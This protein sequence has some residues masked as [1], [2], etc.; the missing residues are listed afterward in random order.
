MEENQSEELKIMPRGTAPRSLRKGRQHFLLIVFRNFLDLQERLPA[1][2]Q[3]L[4]SRLFDSRIY[5]KKF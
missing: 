5:V 1:E 3:G 4:L 2:L